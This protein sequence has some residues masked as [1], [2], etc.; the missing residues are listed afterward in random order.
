MYGLLWIHNSF[1]VK[2]TF[3]HPLQHTH[4]HTYPSSVLLHA[5]SLLRNVCLCVRPVTGKEGGVQA[6]RN[7]RV[8]KH[9]LQFCFIQNSQK[10]T[11]TQDCMKTYTYIQLHKRFLFMYT[12]AAACTH[13]RLCFQTRAHSYL[14]TQCMHTLQSSDVSCQGN[15]H[16]HLPYTNTHTFVIRWR[17]SAEEQKAIC[18]SWGN[19]PHGKTC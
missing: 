18:F 9:T 3:V 12:H 16:R 7:T 2:D 6:C 14:Y 10:C 15:T 5:L 19:I 11:Q 4:T 13:I 17:S 1:R 8:S